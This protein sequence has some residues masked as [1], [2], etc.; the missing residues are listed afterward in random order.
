[1]DERNRT[2]D[3][4]FCFDLS[5]WKVVGPFSR[6]EVGVGEEWGNT[7]RG[8]FGHGRFEVLCSGSLF[9]TLSWVCRRL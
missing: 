8:G 9:R 2:Q 5:T 6:E 7:V 3:L 4:R 1:M